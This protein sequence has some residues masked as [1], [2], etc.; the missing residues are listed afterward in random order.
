MTRTKTTTRT[1]KATGVA[2]ITAAY[3]ALT[4]ALKIQAARALA[5][6]TP[7]GELPPATGARPITSTTAPKAP[8]TAID[9]LTAIA[10]ND[11]CQDFPDRLPVAERL[12]AA[13]VR[14]SGFSD[15]AIEDHANQLLVDAGDGLWPDTVARIDALKGGD[16]TSLG[17]EDVGAISSYCYSVAGASFALGLV[18]GM[19]IGGGR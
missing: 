3:E 10:G 7:D 17:A 8:I 1:P 19:K 14:G 16:V 13:L 2:T 18:A 9:V 4:P 6:L 12:L 5:A 11:D 15:C